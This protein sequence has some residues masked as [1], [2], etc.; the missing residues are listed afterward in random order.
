MSACLLSLVS[1][2]FHRSICGHFK[3]SKQGSIVL[4]DIDPKC[5][6]KLLDLVFG[7][8]VAV[9]DSLGDAVALAV[10]A[11]RLHITT[12]VADALEAAIAR[13]LTLDTAAELLMSAAAATMPRAAA[14][15]RAMLLDGFAAA[16]QT[17]EF[18]SWSEALLADLL[19]DDRC[20]SCAPARA[21]LRAA[22]LVA[23]PDVPNRLL[24]TMLAGPGSRARLGGVKR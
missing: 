3:E 7:A 14:A 20:C 22:R 2:V 15:A 23:S 10:L 21:A 13:S 9:L 11:D 1:P 6:T 8:R 5:F 17:Q 4:D 18:L 16:S 12:A 19:G 24:G